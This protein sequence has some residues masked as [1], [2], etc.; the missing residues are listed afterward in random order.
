LE[1]RQ[2]KKTFEAKVEQSK[3]VDDVNLHKTLVKDKV[4]TFKT[5]L[6]AALN[7]ILE[8]ARNDDTLKNEFVKL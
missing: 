2:I 8:D 3:T 6:E 4:E 7:K 5:T 1:I